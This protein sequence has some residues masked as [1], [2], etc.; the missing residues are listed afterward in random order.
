MKKTVRLLCILLAAML[1][2][3]SCNININGSHVGNDYLY[4][5][6]TAVRNV[7]TGS[8]VFAS[9][10]IKMQFDDI[11]K[12]LEPIYP[13]LLK[14][15]IEE[16]IIFKY[17]VYR[18]YDFSYETVHD[19]FHEDN[20]KYEFDEWR[21]QPLDHYLD[22]DMST[23][24]KGNVTE[25]W[26]NTQQYLDTTMLFKG[27]HVPRRY[28]DTL[29]DIP[30]YSLPFIMAEYNPKP[31]CLALVEEKNLPTDFVWNGNGT[32]DNA[33]SLDQF[34]KIYGNAKEINVIVTATDKT[35][36]YDLTDFLF[37]LYDKN[38]YRNLD[39]IHING[40]NM[41]TTADIGRLLSRFDYVDLEN[42]TF[43]NDIEILQNTETY[44]KLTNCKYNKLTC[45]DD[46][47]IRLDGCTG[48]KVVIPR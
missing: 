36:S 1:M 35:G 25:A 44:W 23:F 45:Y 47:D 32:K 7:K 29:D 8:Y 13:K 39:E 9:A 15:D 3:P 10:E 38:T 31:V 17:P 48:N 4:V 30:V 34:R 18:S 42:I 16:N 5:K 14:E 22:D 46:T 28:I 12:E 11:T 41:T 6:G 21:T 2:L 26:T 24:E 40:N 33:Y 19:E 27:C 43:K 37:E 20:E